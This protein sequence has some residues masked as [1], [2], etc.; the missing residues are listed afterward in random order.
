MCDSWTFKS[1]EGDFSASQTHMGANSQFVKYER[2][3]LFVLGG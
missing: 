2:F 1:E 3:Q